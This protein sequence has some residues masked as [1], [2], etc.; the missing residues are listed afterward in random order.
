MGTLVKFTCIP[1]MGK[2][3]GGAVW[4]STAGGKILNKATGE[5]GVRG[6]TIA[7]F[8][9]NGEFETSDAKVIKRL[10]E[11]D[12]KV[13][14]E[15]G[16]D[17]AT[18]TDDLDKMTKD[19]LVQYAADKEIELPESCTKDVIKQLIADTMCDSA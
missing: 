4:D 9:K 13:I 16:T 17:G 6:A 5:M 18:T 12:F 3:G 1:Q 7:R 19:Q 2:E 11:M 10:K 14:S 15:A 8:D